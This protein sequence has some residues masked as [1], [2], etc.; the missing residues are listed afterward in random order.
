MPIQNE[1]DVK[2]L[3]ENILKDSKFNLSELKK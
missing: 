1:V 2:E 3:N